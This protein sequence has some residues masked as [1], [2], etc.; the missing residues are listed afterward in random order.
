M[1]YIVLS[2]FLIAFNLIYSAYTI[3]FSRE[4]VQKTME[5][6]KESERNLLLKVK[7]AKLI[8][9]TKAKKWSVEKGFVPIDWEKVGFVD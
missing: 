1:R 5:L 4:Y 3:K 2:V 9:Y 7:Y 6:K 8:N